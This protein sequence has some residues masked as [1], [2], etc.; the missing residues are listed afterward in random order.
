[1]QDRF[2]ASHINKQWPQAAKHTQWPGTGL[3]G[4]TIFDAFYASTVQFVANETHEQLAMQKA[5]AALLDRIGRP[6][7]LVGHSQAGMYP[8]LMA[9]VRPN[10]VAAMVLIEPKGPPF[11]ETVFS[12]TAS[13]KWGVTDAPMTY[14][15]PVTDHGEL[16]KVVSDGQNVQCILQA[17]SPPPRKFAN[18]AHIPILVVTAEASY[19][20][21]YDDC[22]VA[23]YRQAGC[24]VEHV[25]LA[26]IGIHGNGHMMLLEKNSH[27][28]QVV[29]EAWI[30][31]H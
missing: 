15:P 1:M 16:I 31:R 10:L 4:D 25:E 17:E 11:Q 19:H 20:A 28:I 18:I 2:T 12:K 27:A 3:M 7:I 26:N 24:T 8:P 9:D 14:E 21:Q 30:R 23:Y 6:V 29:L 22:T 5:G 13:R